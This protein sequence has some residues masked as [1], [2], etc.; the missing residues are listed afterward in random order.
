VRFRCD[1][2]DV[3]SGTEFAI[4]RASDLH[5][6]PL[7]ISACPKCSS[8]RT[9]I[10]GYSHQPLLTYIRCDACGHVFVPQVSRS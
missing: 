7:P 8:D 3:A 9:K 6:M 5:K 1:W 10:I 2:P 4:P